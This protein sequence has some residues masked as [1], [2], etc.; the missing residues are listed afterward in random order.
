MFLFCI[1]L[2]LHS[3]YLAI[4]FCCTLFMLIYSPMCIQD[5]HKY[6][7]WKALQ[8]QL[9]KPLNIVTKL[10][11]LDV[12]GGPGYVSTISMLHFF[13]VALS[14]L[15]FFNIEK[16]WKWT[17]DRK[18]NQKNDLT[19]SIVNLFHFYFDILLHI[20]VII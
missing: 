7:R 17:K 19:L 3:S 20:F 11:I 6:L 2:L 13:N 14:M 18:H 10:S 5:H 12:L 9:T 15:H 4:F 16:Y 1:L 8:Q